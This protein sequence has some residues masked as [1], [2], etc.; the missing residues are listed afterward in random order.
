MF[1]RFFYFYEKKT[2]INHP[3]WWY[4]RVPLST[5][6]YDITDLGNTFWDPSSFGNIRI[7]WYFYVVDI[8][9]LDCFDD[10]FFIGCKTFW[11]QITFV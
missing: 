1:F 8:Y 4:G 10:E 6:T 2:K 9:G 3:F 5:V 7:E 11:E